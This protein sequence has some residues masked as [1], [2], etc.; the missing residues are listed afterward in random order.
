M[1]LTTPFDVLT[2]SLNDVWMM[3]DFNYQLPKDNL[4]EY[5]DEKCVLHPTN[6]HCK[7]FD[8]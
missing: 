4:T 1:E 2:N 3:H 7:T 6:S 5:R 8:D